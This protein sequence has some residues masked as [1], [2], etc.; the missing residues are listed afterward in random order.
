MLKDE[1]LQRRLKINKQVNEG[2]VL[3]AH[4][5]RELLNTA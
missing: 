1:E 2:I 3:E 5:K 4:V